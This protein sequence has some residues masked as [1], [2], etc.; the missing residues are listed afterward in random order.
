MNKN[1]KIWLAIWAIL[2]VIIAFSV[3]LYFKNNNLT[4]NDILEW[5][6][7][8]E[9]KNIE[10]S[11]E[12]SNS[13]IDL[14][15]KKIKLKW[16]ITKA[17]MYYDEN[18]HIIALF[19]YQQ[20]LKDIP[21]DE[22]INI[23]V[24]DIYY[25]M[26]KFKK[27]N[28]YYLKFKNSKFLDKDKAILS[29]V[30][31]KWVS[32]ENIL[33]LEKEIDSFEISD[34]KKFYY[35]NSI[36][37]VI[38]YSLCREN[39]QKYFEKNKNIES[40][41]MKIIE[42]AFEN[43]KNFR[44]NDIYYKAAFITWAFYQNSFYYVAL[45]TSENILSQKN[46][47]SPI[48][49]VAAKSAYEIWDY[50]KAKNYLIELKKSF[51]NDPEISYFLWRIYEKLKDRVL[52]L[53]HYK[54][55]ISDNYK[56]ITDVKRRIVFLYFEGWETKKML[57]AFDELLNSDIK[58][59]NENDFSLAIYYN[60]LNENFKKAEDYSKKAIELFENNAL[61]YWYYSW[62][63]L[64][65]DDLTSRDLKIIEENIDKSLKINNKEPMI[66]MVK[67]IY[68][69]KM[70]HYDKSIITLKLAHWLDKNWE[71]KDI[72]NYWL[73]KVLKEK[74]ENL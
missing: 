66:L 35:K 71:Y 42:S 40:E 48:M 58:N 18:E 25:K 73:N 21:K 19:Q 16:L 30:N 55:A 36:S 60:I 2:T 12:K 14:L 59:L 50:I 63:L 64:Q 74:N 28:E 39:F 7:E 38:D 51:W 4:A 65:N 15:K 47:Y 26:N 1:L 27:A 67:W 52:A 56:D 72:I 68:E 34:E 69:L 33:E 10:I 41:E 9:L 70:K 23:K 53:V 44:T 8:E 61:F 24:W 29:L 6:H 57:S 32:K 49:K 5:D 62:I 45:K 54:K 3:F 20:I 13:K 31:E 46:N 17:N 11:W 22:E 37:C 43:Y